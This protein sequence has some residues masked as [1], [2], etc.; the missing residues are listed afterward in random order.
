VNKDIILKL[1]KEEM[2]PA[3][4]VTEPSTIALA[5]ARA[6]AETEGEINKVELILDPGIYKNTYSCGIPNTTEKGIEMAVLLGVV[7]GDYNLGLQVLQNITSKDVKKAKEL[8]E[9]IYIDIKV[10]EGYKD[11]YVNSKIYTEQSI[12]LVTIKDR[13]DNI[14]HLAVDGQV[15]FDKD[16]EQKESDLKRKNPFREIK[17]EEILKFINDIEFKDIKFTLDAVK[18]NK[19]LAQKGKVGPGMGLGAG[20]T[21]LV[22]DNEIADDIANYAQRLTAFS[23]DARMGVIPK[24]AMSFCGSGDHGIIATLPL[25]AVT[26]RKKISKDKLAKSIILSYIITYYIKSKTGK[27]SAYCGCAIAAGSGAC[28]GIAYLL[29]GNEEQIVG[30]INNMVGNITG[31]ICD[32]GNYG[33]SLK[34]ATAASTAVESALLAVNNY[35]LNANNGIVGKDLQE[36]LDN[37]GQIAEPGMEQTNHV[38]LDI[39]KER[40]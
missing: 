11:I 12:S 32:G 21:N 13:H 22:K 30:A 4:G 18:M 2:A 27:L 3:L 23:V 10:K 28:A 17:I 26:E 15:I 20:L 14:S 34:A 19:K 39:L 35:Y 36:T 31:M 33:C 40:E 37:M 29:G 25:T 7:N 5:T 1:L 8:K 16:E 24:P 9:N 38:I 6:V